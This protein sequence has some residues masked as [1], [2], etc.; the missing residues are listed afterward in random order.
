MLERWTESDP[1]LKEILPPPNHVTTWLL[2]KLLKSRSLGVFQSDMVG[3]L[4]TIGSSIMAFCSKVPNVSKPY[5][6]LLK[7]IESSIIIESGVQVERDSADGS[8]PPVL[9]KVVDTAGTSCLTGEMI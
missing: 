3:S 9:K 8:K 7:S 2:M 1:N 6:G 4:T 5:M